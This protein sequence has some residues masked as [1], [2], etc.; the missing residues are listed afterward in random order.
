M[1]KGCKF[2]LWLFAVSLIE[3]NASVASANTYDMFVGTGVTVGSAYHASSDIAIKPSKMEYN[4]QHY[5]VGFTSALWEKLSLNYDSD[6]VV[7]Y[8]EGD[9]SQVIR[10]G[11]AVAQTYH[12]LGASRANKYGEE[13]TVVEKNHYSISLQLKQ[14]LQRFNA[15]YENGTKKIDGTTLSVVIGIEMR[16]PITNLLGLGI[17]QNSTIG[18]LPFGSDLLRASEKQ[19][20]L[21][22]DFLW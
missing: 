6:F 13:V 3:V 1:S 22:F 11:A 16:F 21:S 4:A 20:T 17:S 7:L 9:T 10:Y 19:T 12:L 2:I 18:S 15:K 8:A 14:K 5:V